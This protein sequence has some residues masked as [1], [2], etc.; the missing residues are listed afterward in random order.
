MT[1]KIQINYKSGQT[2]TVSAEIFEVT[3]Q[4]DKLSGIDWKEIKPYPLLMNLDA[5]ESIWELT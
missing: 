5:I 3:T 1:A 2:I 4:G